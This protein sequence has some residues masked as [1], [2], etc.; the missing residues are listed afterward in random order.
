ME[1]LINNLGTVLVV[2]IVSNMVAWVC[3][4]GVVVWLHTITKYC[5]AAY[6]NQVIK[7]S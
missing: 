3:L 2:L 6:H 7:E 4:F 1:W 5:V